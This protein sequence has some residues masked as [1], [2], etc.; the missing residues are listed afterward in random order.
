MKRIF[1]SIALLALG[2]PAYAEDARIAVTTASG[3]AAPV[4]LTAPVCGVDSSGAPVLCGGGGNG[5]LAYKD[6]SGQYQTILPVVPV[7][8]VTADGVP[9][10][11]NFSSGTTDLSAYL[12]KTDAQAEYSQL[13]AQN[14]FTAEQH[15]AYAYFADPDNNVQRDAKFG[16]KGIAVTGGT[17]TDTLNVTTSA[18]VPD[19][20]TTDSTKSA[21]NTESAAA[22]FVSQTAASSTYETIAGM[23]NYALA[24]NGKLTTPTITKPSIDGGTLTTD[25]EGNWILSGN[26]GI[27]FGDAEWLNY[28]ATDGYIAVNGDLEITGRVNLPTRTTGDNG[29]Y[30]AST[31]FVQNTLNAERGSVTGDLSASGSSLTL[32]FGTT[33]LQL[34]LS[35]ASAGTASLSAVSTSGSLT[36]VDIYEVA[37]YG[38]T[39]FKGYTLDSGTITTTATVIDSTFWLTSNAW[40]TYH[41]GIG[42][43]LYTVDIFGSGAGKRAVMAWRKES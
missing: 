8:S 32:A 5:N 2:L 36:P 30:A 21:L 17:K 27:K 6:A 41:V 7:C 25:G 15:F 42:G 24:T 22:R 43:H 34:T 18:S 1:A 26:N 9:Q 40:G 38:T 13:A 37:A 29:N 10:T 20:T 23:A 11:C 39:S 4:T 35:Y 31:A 14:S 12:T 19:T 33:G 16:D 28:N 3:Q